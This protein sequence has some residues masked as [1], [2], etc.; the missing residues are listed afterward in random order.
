M[1]DVRPGR[2]RWWSSRRPACSAPAPEPVPDID[3]FLADMAVARAVAA[4][5]AER[6]AQL[7]MGPPLRDLPV[8]WP[9]AVEAAEP[10]PEPELE[11][12]PR[13]SRRKPNAE[14]PTRAGIRATAAAKGGPLLPVDLDA[15]DEEDLVLAQRMQLAMDLWVIGLFELRGGGDEVKPDVWRVADVHAGRT[16]THVYVCR[17]R[18]GCYSKPE[19][20]AVRLAD[21]S[22]KI[23][24]EQGRRAHA[25]VERHRGR[26]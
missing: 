26:S 25:L 14:R 7:P 23:T 6:Q 2:A 3:G 4:A 1:M 9:P 22:W 12:A 5:G 10:D 20:T 19:P 15:L 17:R 18:V 21:G 13:K 24:Q 11:A 8:Y 16:P